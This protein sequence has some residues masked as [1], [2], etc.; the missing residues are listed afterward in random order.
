MDIAGYNDGT[1]DVDGISFMD[2]IEIAGKKVII[3]TQE[4]VVSFGLHIH[5]MIQSNIT[6]QWS[7]M[8][9][10]DHLVAWGGLLL[11]MQQISYMVCVPSVQCMKPHIVIL[12]VYNSQFTQIVTITLLLL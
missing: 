7:I 3:I 11:T 4:C 10:E 6:L 9:R 2:A 8:A 5:R 12:F 1:S